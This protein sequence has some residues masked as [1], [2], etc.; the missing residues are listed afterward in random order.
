M[1]LNINNVVFVSSINKYIR[2][3]FLFEPFS[4]HYFFIDG[5]PYICFDQYFT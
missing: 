3:I 2:W 1:E 5:S 4:Y